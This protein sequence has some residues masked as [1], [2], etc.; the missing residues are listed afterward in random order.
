MRATYFLLSLVVTLS[1]VACGSAKETAPEKPPMPVADTV[2]APT[3]K[4]LDKARSV[5]GTLQQDK[6]N[7]D[8][9]LNAAE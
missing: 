3:I 2:F 5:E 1:L 4:T 6:D 7:V 8:A 9:A